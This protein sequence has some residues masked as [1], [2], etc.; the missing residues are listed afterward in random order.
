MIPR[1]PIGGCE[2]LKVRVP[3]GAPL[4]SRM[5]RPLLA[6]LWPPLAVGSAGF[7]AFLLVRFVASGE[8]DAVLFMFPVLVF[9][10][11]AFTGTLAGHAAG[12]LCRPWPAAAAIGSLAA[13]MGQAVVTLL[14][15]AGATAAGAADLWGGIGRSLLF[16]IAAAAAG[17]LAAVGSSGTGL[18][19]TD[20][21]AHERSVRPG[22][23][24]TSLLCPRCGT[25][26]PTA[27]AD[28]PCPRCGSVELA[29]AAGPR[30]GAVTTRGP[31]RARA[32][33]AKKPR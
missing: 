1:A 5:L 19:G 21:A 22:R 30:S 2:T 33:R 6:G 13:A 3:T 31:V 4:R 7:V 23:A 9:A 11:A 17:G 27:A 14:A 20:R 29:A 15:F 10:G 25:A 12:R 16:V 8:E 28:A 32:P 26:R 18:A 24:G